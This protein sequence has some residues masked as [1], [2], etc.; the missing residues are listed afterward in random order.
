MTK[1]INLE[2]NKSK[3]ITNIE[4]TQNI[5]L[6]EIPNA[7]YHINADRICVAPNIT[8]KSA[9]L[10]DDKLELI[11]LIDCENEISEYQDQELTINL[12]YEKDTGNYIFDNIISEVV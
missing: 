4:E 9:T 12:K 1:I 7:Y 8:L 3:P 6:N 5:V 11:I 2:K 10:K